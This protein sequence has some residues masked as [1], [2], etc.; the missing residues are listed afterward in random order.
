MYKQFENQKVF[1]WMF[2]VLLTVFWTL[3]SF[4][5]LTDKAPSECDQN[6]N[7][8]NFVEVVRLSSQKNAKCQ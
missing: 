8:I 6:Q 7:E 4:F 1:Q 2:I 3:L 5:L